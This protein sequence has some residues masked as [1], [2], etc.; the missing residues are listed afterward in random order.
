MELSEKAFLESMF[1]RVSAAIEKIEL[2][3]RA[4]K[5]WIDVSIVVQHNPAKNIRLGFGRIEGHGHQHLYVEWY[6]GERLAERRR[7]RDC[8]IGVRIDY[9]HEIGTLILKIVAYH[10]TKLPD[11]EKAALAY[12]EVVES[13][14]SNKG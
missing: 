14:E 3:L 1:D 13:L 10:K 11:V 4:Q 8:P 7:L 12:E 5:Y 2:H 9:G 6:D